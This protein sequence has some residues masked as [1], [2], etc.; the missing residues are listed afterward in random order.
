MRG[1]LSDEEDTEKYCVDFF[2]KGLEEDVSQMP[3]ATDTSTLQAQ[4]TDGDNG[5]DFL[6]NNTKAAGLGRTTATVDRSQHKN[7]VR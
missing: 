5:D 3:Q 7:F 2:R 4:D 1:E 6:I